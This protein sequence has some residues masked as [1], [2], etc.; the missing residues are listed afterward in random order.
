MIG[1]NRFQTNGLIG[2]A[3]IAVLATLD[4]ALG[5]GGGAFLADICRTVLEDE[6]SGGM[7]GM[8]ME[9]KPVPLIALSMAATGAAIWA[10]TREHQR[11]EAGRSAPDGE[12]QAAILSA[13]V[14]V[15]ASQGRT[16]REEIRDV[17][18]IVTEHELDEDL[19]DLA[20]ERYLAM[21][22]AEKPRHRMPP[23]SS[24]I[25]RRRTLAAALIMGCVARR[26]TETTPALIERIALDIGATTD[27]IAVARQSLGEWQKDCQPASGVSPVTV[28]RHRSLRL[29]PV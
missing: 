12:E 9:V 11:E 19:V 29:A 2:L 18:R 13:M 15:A 28:L 10:M 5:L 1:V 3:G 16:S 14:I 26:S 23:V 21:V 8:A 27:D 20:Y 22:E 4:S 6:P 25:G 24:S 7:G 17:F